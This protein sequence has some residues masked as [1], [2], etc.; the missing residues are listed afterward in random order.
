[1]VIHREWQVKEYD[2][3]CL[4]FEIVKATVSP[5]THS[6][7]QKLKCVSYVILTFCSLRIETWCL[8]WMKAIE[9][10]FQIGCLFYIIPHKNGK[11]GFYLVQ[12]WTMHSPKSRR[13]KAVGL[14][15]TE[16]LK[17]I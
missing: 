13:N 10:Y 2:W 15:Q 9:Q 1:M 17:R 14:V 12:Y 7:I 8:I 16:I 6:H 3:N 5:V 4:S 11:N